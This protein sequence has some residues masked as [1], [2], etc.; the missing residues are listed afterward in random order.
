MPVSRNSRLV[1]VRVAGLGVCVEKSV[2][3]ENFVGVP[4]VVG[5]AVRPL[6]S[7]RVRRVSPLNVSVAPLLPFAGWLSSWRAAKFFADGEGFENL[8]MSPLTRGEITLAAL[9]LFWL[10][11]VRK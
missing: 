3:V 9:R 5:L 8:Q 2:L 1:L 6:L 7:C 11:L 4:T 10:A